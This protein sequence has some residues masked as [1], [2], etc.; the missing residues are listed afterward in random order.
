MQVYLSKG[1][2]VSFKL[3]DEGSN[4][5]CLRT[6]LVD[7][8]T[9]YSAR[10][11]RRSFASSLPHTLRM[12]FSPPHPCLA[13][14]KTTI[15]EYGKSARWSLSVP[16]SRRVDAREV[17]IAAEGLRTQLAR[18]SR[19]GGKVQLLM[20]I[21]ELI[22]LAKALP[23]YHFWLATSF[24]TPSGIATILQSL[25]Q[26]RND[27]R[28]DWNELRCRSPSLHVRLAR[29]LRLLP[30]GPYLPK[31]RSQAVNRALLRL[32]NEMQAQPP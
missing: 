9:R 27:I 11:L 23:S 19:I 29:Q 8:V 16:H 13:E 17:E 31:Q 25:Q 30:K 12:C 26:L 22:Q 6:R 7:Q 3:V 2:G 5:E 28:K 24:Y 15:V 4:L 32:V 18:F 1:I 20:P 14:M 10:M 21:E